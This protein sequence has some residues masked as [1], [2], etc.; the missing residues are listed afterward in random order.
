[1]PASLSWTYERLEASFSPIYFVRPKCISW[2]V[3]YLVLTWN[4]VPKPNQNI[5]CILVMALKQWVRRSSN[6]AS[7]LMSFQHEAP[8]CTHTHRMTR[9]LEA[10]GLSTNSWQLRTLKPYP[11]Q[12]CPLISA[13]RIVMGSRPVF[14]TLNVLLREKFGSLTLTPAVNK[15]HLN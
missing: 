11:S 8:P 12:T 14:S 5:F 4:A 13:D 6:D 1:M 10:F 2:L 3:G 15:Y 7:R 9:S